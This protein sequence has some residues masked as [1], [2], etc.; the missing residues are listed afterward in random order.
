MTQK[1]LA[2]A[3][4][5]VIAYNQTGNL[6]PP[7][8]QGLYLGDTRGLSYHETIKLCRY[9]YRRDTI[10]G[11]VIDRIAE[12]SNT[13][14]R[15]KRKSIHN[16]DPISDEIL[17]YYNVV[18]DRLNIFFKTA[19]VEYLVD[20]LVV[21]QYELE[22]EMGSRLSTKLGRTRYY[23]PKALWSRNPENLIIKK[24]YDI[25]RTIYLKIPSEDIEFI[26]TEGRKGTSDEDLEGYALL[27]ES[28][29]EYV[30]A[31]K[32]GKT[33]FKLNTNPIFRKM[34]S[35]TTYPI[36]YLEPALDALDYKRY[37]K[38]L[39]KSIATRAIESFRHI[40]V[41]SDEYPADDDDILSVQTSLQQQSSIERVYNF[42]TNH[43]ISVSWVVPPTDILLDH[44]KYEEANADIFFAVGFPRILTVGETEK[45][46]AAD[47]KIAVVGVLSTFEEVQS[48]FLIWIKKL[49]KELAD[50]NGFL[51]IPEPY[52]SKIQMADVTNLLQY[53][54]DLIENKTISKNTAAQIYGSDYETESEQIDLENKE[55]ENEPENIGE[56]QIITA[57][58]KE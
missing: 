28:F 43:T 34:L 53:V 44:D 9:F 30:E 26:K 24:N 15:N 10:A 58:T 14:L 22:R 31:V 35:F 4:Y 11:T 2:K 13:K 56:D 40:K 54:Y 27:L 49:Y 51:K 46:N 37:L 36:P 19:M 25:N 45:S 32:A 41:G 52:F 21:P 55:T 33:R 17:A 39:D 18:A 48:S 16:S 7:M 29:P 12:I 3:S 57:T 42:F 1:K 50:K 38:M 23:F 47:N 5:N 6:I 8:Y 20:G